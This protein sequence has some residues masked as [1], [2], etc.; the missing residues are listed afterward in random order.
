MAKDHNRTD[1]WEDRSVVYRKFRY[2]IKN[3][4]YVFDVDQVE[5]R[6][7]EAGMIPVAVIELTRPD[8][9]VRYPE[10]YLPVVVQR[11][12][13]GNPQHDHLVCVSEALKVD[14]WIVVFE[15]PIS[16]FWVMNATTNGPWYELNPHAYKKW[17]ILGCPRSTRRSN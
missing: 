17:L 7:T 12:L 14:L 3:K 2:E 9:V 4:T 13:S 1:D 11:Y 15:N 6:Q 10:K 16:R 5:Y 8:D